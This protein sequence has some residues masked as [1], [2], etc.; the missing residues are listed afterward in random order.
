MLPI[1]CHG[2]NCSDELCPELSRWSAQSSVHEEC[3][4]TQDL[5]LLSCLQPRQW[6]LSSFGNKKIRFR[7]SSPTRSCV[8]QPDT[9]LVPIWAWLKQQASPKMRQSHSTLFSSA[10]SAVCDVAFALFLSALEA[11]QHLYSPQNHFSACIQMG[12]IV[13]SWWGA[14]LLW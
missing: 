7:S 5:S 4:F 10:W 2:Y 13:S 14:S 12:V 11:A 6:N 3:W 1:S 9:G 8:Y